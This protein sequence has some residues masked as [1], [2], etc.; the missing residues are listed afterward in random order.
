MCTR[1][2][3]ND[4]HLLASTNIRERGLRCALT[5]IRNARQL[6][7]Q[8]STAQA[9]PNCRKVCVCVCR[10]V[11]A[12]DDGPIRTALDI[13]RLPLHQVGAHSCVHSTS[14]HA[15]AWGP[16]RDLCLTVVQTG[17]DNKDLDCDS[18]GIFGSSISL[19]DLC[20]SDPLCAIGLLWPTRRACIRFRRL[21][22]LICSAT[23]QPQ[24]PCSVRRD[25]PCARSHRL[26]AC[27]APVAPKL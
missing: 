3:V 5:N 13:A 16:G 21:S 11:V 15:A 10:L 8:R 4:A 14:L 20:C 12:G 23:V 19:T 6:Q 9:L 1:W 26:G 24:L 18:G 2:L 7:T 17:I 27:A 25:Q 22:V